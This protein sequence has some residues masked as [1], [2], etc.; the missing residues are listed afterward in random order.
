MMAWV[1]LETTGLDVDRDVILEVG[2]AIT[3]DDLT[4][5]QKHSFV[6]NQPR[7]TMGMPIDEFVRTM[8]TKN[9]LLVEH[10][11]GIYLDRVEARLIEI[12]QTFDTP[13]PLCGSSVHFDRAFMKRYM[14]AWEACFHYRNIDTSTNKELV[15]RWPVFRGDVVRPTPLKLHRVNPDLTDSI[16]EMRYY[17]ELLFDRN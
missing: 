6:V 13:P 8:H 1:D 2:L 7:V 14:P 9:G 17:K 11:T 10:E 4:L 12:M 5:L 16:A 15:E 3:L